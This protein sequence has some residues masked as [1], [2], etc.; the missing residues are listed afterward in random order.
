MDTFDTADARFRRIFDEN[1]EAIRAYCLRRLPPDEADEATSEVFLVVWRR[2]GDVPPGESARPWIFGVAR[3][4]IRDL[5][6]KR[7]RAFRLR[8]RLR[9]LADGTEPSPEGVIVAGSEYREV[10]DAFQRLRT[11]D[12]EVLRLRLWE[13]L[14]MQDIAVVL[15]CSEK[16]ASKRYQRALVRLAQLAESKERQRIRP[17]PARRGGER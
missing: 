3:N 1:I 8:T 2:M 15:R 9:G 7:R 5:D 12:R 16:A 17:H 13:E 11:R 14:S 4:T 6:R 10:I